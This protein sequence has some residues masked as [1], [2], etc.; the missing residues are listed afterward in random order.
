MVA[1]AATQEENPMAEREADH[2]R[3]NRDAWNEYAAEFVEMG[4]Q[5]G[6]AD[7]P[8]WGIWSVPETYLGVLPAELDGL[9]VVE[10]GCGTAYVS[11]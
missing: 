9:D 6:A 5:N 8:S 7:E 10:L 4:E 11:A 1:R 2:V 3:R